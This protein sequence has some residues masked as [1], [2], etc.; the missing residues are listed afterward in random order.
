[1]LNA[2]Q[3][4]LVEVAVKGA[5]FRTTLLVNVRENIGCKLSAERRLRPANTIADY[6]ESSLRAGRRYVDDVRRTRLPL[7]RPRRSTAEHEDHRFTLFDES[8][9]SEVFMTERFRIQPW[10][11]RLSLVVSQ[12]PLLFLARL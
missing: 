5:I 10:L 8:E 6:V 12:S 1:L 7:T 3:R 9:I 11:P 2:D 4:C